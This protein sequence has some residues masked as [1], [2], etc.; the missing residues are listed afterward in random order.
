M[1]KKLGRERA[2]A[3]PRGVR[4]HDA[5]HRVDGGRAD[6]AARA[7]AARGGRGRGHEGIGAVIEIEKHAVRAL[8]EDVLALADFVVEEA[9]GI[10][11]E[12]AN[13]FAV[14]Q[15]FLDQPIEIGL[16][17]AESRQRR[18]DVGDV[19]F[20]VAAQPL[21]PQQILDAQTGA[22]GLAFVGGTDAT[23]G[24]SDG[25]RLGL[26][27]AIEIAMMGK[28]QVGAAGDDQILVA[29]PTGPDRGRS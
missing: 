26:A 13:L 15:V 21:G 6:A 12:G 24:G 2:V 7:S 4:L 28:G 20:E 16:C 18:R 22:R 14:G 29:W 8:E 9:R 19:A 11:H 5:H 10:A 17:G 23:L 27:R 1:S 25:A 3:N